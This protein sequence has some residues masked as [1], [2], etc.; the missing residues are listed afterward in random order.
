MERKTGGGG[1]SSSYSLGLPRT[2][3]SPECTAP[4]SGLLPSIIKRTLATT[5][6]L[7]NHPQCSASCL[8]ILILVLISSTVKPINTELYYYLLTSSQP[9]PSGFWSSWKEVRL[10][11]IMTMTVPQSSCR[12]KGHVGLWSK[13]FKAVSLRPSSGHKEANT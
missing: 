13:S 6:D 1:D 9:N 3:Q 8:Y 12:M 10:T 11:E 7:T 4:H 5:S 2:I